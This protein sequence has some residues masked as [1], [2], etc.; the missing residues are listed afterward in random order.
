[1]ELFTPQ[2]GLNVVMKCRKNQLQHFLDDKLFFTLPLPPTISFYLLT[3]VLNFVLT[4]LK[5]HVCVR[6]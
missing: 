1:M 5:S 2:R 4:F 3:F 6:F